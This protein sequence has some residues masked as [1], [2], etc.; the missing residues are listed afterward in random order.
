MKK[1]AFTTNADSTRA[2]CRGRAGVGGRQPQMQREERGLGQQS[3]RHQRGCNQ[4][5]GFGVHPLGQQHDVERAVGAVE[6]GRAD[7]IEDRAKQREDQIAQ[8]SRERLRAAIQADQRHR[9]ERQQLQRDVQREEITARKT[10][11]SAP[12]I[13]SSKIQNANGARAS[14]DPAAC[15]NPLAQRLRWRRSRSP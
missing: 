5:H 6:Q 10:V 4:G 11:F 14:S 13:A 3:R 9:G 12:Q 8:R 15:G 1:D 7:Q 2:R